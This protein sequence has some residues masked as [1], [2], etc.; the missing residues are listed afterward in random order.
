[1]FAAIFIGYSMGTAPIVSYNFGAENHA[2]LKNIF[3]KSLA[4]ISATSIAMVAAFT[5][6][7]E[8]LFKLTKLAFR[9]YSFSFL[10]CGVN[11]YGSSFFT[12][13]NN[14]IVSAVLSVLRTLG[15]QVPFILVLPVMLGAN[16]IWLASPAAEVACMILTIA[17]L[18]AFRKKYRYGK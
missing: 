4:V 6:Y 7:D 2:E 9:I 12:A 18:I 1:M 5:S 13:L 3:K 16:G 15:F 14:G 11:I 17:C 10:V 8:N